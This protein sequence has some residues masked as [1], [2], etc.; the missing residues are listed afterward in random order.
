MAAAGEQPTHTSTPHEST[1]LL[2]FMNSISRYSVWFHASSLTC[3]LCASALFYLLSQPVAAAPRTF[4]SP[5]DAVRALSTAVNTRD[6]NALG[7]ILGPSIN[8]LRS[9]DPVQARNELTTF[10]AN[11]AASN[12]LSHVSGGR[13]ILETGQDRWPFPIPIVRTN[14]SWFFDTEAGKEE[15]LNRRIGNDELEAL[16]SLRA[17]AQAQREY[18]S[19]DHN[20]D[21]VLQYAQK[22]ISTPGKKDGLYWSPEIDGEISPLGP[23]FA[24]AQAEGYLKQ[25]GTQN[26]PQP[27]HGY[28][29]RILTSQGKHAPGGAYD[30]II[31][32]HMLAGFAFLAWPARYGVSGIMSFIINQQGKVYQRNLGPDTDSLAKQIKTYDPDPDWTV[33][34]D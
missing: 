13:C 22:I 30:Y 7:D 17:G 11:L 21:E 20:G 27:F 28:Y 24:E 12:H 26:A 6:I 9:P 18:A 25:P 3:C 10:A 2:P 19:R 5:E 8:D 31:N 34:K 14:G 32:G 1:T 23:A 15:L 29:F 4:N 16:Q 33:S